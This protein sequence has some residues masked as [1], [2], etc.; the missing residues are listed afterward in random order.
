MPY[1]NK[2][3]KERPGEQHTQYLNVLTDSGILIGKYL[4]HIVHLTPQ[5]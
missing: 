3:E 2:K 4:V 5:Q 1:L